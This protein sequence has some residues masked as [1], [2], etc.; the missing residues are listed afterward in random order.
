MVSQ[1]AG[2]LKSFGLGD[3]WADEQVACCPFENE[4]KLKRGLI[5]LL[6]GGCCSHIIKW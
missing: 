3:C 5:N 4:L 2:A 6:K 1:S